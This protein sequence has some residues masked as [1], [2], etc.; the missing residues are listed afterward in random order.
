MQVSRVAHVVRHERAG[1]A[2]L[3]LVG[4]ARLRM[5]PH[6]VVDDELTPPVEQ[7]GQARLSAR[8]R[9]DVLLADLD[10]GQGAATDVDRVF[11]PDG[12]LFPGKQFLTGYQPFTS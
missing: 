10:G 11:R 2:A 3:I 1:R 8:P 9:E 4:E 6:E 7:V 12:F 5:A